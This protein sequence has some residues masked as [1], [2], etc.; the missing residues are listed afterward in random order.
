MNIVKTAHLRVADNRGDLKEI[1]V[2]FTEEGLYITPEG[3]EKGWP[4]RVGFSD[5]RVTLTLVGDVKENPTDLI[6]LVK[7]Q[8]E[9]KLKEKLKE[10]PEDKK[11]LELPLEYR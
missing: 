9:K 7:E 5:G 10:K 8:H 2:E 11:Q 1:Q 6:D 3:S 4:L